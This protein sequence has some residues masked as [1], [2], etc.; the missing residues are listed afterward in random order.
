MQDVIRDI[1]L[2]V[3]IARP[4]PWVLL[5]CVCAILLLLLLIWWWYKRR[6][7]PEKPIVLPP[8]VPPGKEAI[9]A[10]ENLEF[11]EVK[12]YYT[13][14]SLIV[15]RFIERRFKVQ[16]PEQTTD[17]FLVHASRSANLSDQYKSMLEVFLREA[18]MIKF[19][20]Y[21]VSTSHAQDAR[22]P[23]SRFVEESHEDELFLQAYETEAQAHV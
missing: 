4:F 1:A 9:L 15:R 23:L 16:A 3:E 7:T 19:A 2:D 6:V 14:L 12:I 8:P 10:L 13:E 22:A 5:L 11:T 18:D 21:T 17:E 20:K